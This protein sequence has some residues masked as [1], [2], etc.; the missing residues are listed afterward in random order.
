MLGQRKG[1][2]REREDRERGERRLDRKREREE[3]V[4]DGRKERRKRSL[5]MGGQCV[6]D[7]GME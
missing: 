5:E 7:E 6:G 4:G 2:R 1:G 3:R